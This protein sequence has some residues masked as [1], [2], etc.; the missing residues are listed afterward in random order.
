[1]P[2]TDCPFFLWADGIYRPTLQIR[3]INPHTGL[4]LR[5]YG[6]IDTGAD[7]CAVPAS[8]ADL[9][10]HNLQAGSQKMAAT[11]NGQTIA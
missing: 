4:N 10:G 7:E 9:L 8:Y 1:M 3:I 5:A 2:L 6:I 11:G